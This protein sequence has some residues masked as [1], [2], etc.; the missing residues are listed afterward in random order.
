MKIAICLSGQ[1]RNYMDGYHIFNDLIAKN[2]LDVDYYYH[3]WVIEDNQKFETSQW[4]NINEKYILGDSKIIEKLN[5]LYKPIAHCF[6][7]PIKFD[8][9]KYK[10]IIAY[11]N[12]DNKYINNI[13]N[14][15]SSFYSLSRVC[16]LF[17]NTCQELGKKYD[18]VIISRFDIT[19]PLNINLHNL[20][21]TKIYA[22]NICLPKKYIVPTTVIIPQNIYIDV[23]N[24]YDNI[25]NILTT[26][27]VYIFMDT[28]NNSLIFNS[29]QIITASFVFW[30]QFNNIVF[31]SDIPN[32]I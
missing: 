29:E 3:T 27:R 21:K 5:N 10:D 12:S 6:D 13:N 1:T 8:H 26:D 30:N 17:N 20:N 7:K 24:L 9:N 25:E 23:Y 14:T 22:S 4:R 32:F 2:N 18:F 16:N 31:T 19:I 15:L 11:K 28:Q